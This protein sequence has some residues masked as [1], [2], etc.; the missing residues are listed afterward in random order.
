LFYLGGGA[1]WQQEQGFVGSKK[2]RQGGRDFLTVQATEEVELWINV[3]TPGLRWQAQRKLQ[4]FL[5]HHHGR[6][7]GLLLAP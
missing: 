6:L 2:L 5:C 7:P 3:H 1:S 4:V